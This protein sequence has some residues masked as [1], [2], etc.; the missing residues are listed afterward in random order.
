MYLSFMRR[1]TKII[2]KK[3]NTEVYVPI[4]VIIFYPFLE[5]FIKKNK[6]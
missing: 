5:N 1:E 3:T 6:G 2:N 4:F